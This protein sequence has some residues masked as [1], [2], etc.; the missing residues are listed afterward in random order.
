[1]VVKIGLVAD[2]QGDADALEYACDLLVE[3]GAER[4]FFLGG[5]WSDVDELF[6]RKRALQRGGREYS[7]RD[8]LADVATFVAKASG[9]EKGTAA[10]ATKENPAEQLIARFARVPDKR[11]LQYRDPAVPRVLPEL[12]GDRIVCLVHDKADLSREDIESATLLIHGHGME[13]AAVQ[14]GSR[15]FLTPGALAGAAT[16]ACALLEVARE[17]S[18]FVGLGLDGRE[19]VRVALSLAGKK[20]MTAR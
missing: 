17:G 14:I 5:F 13:P 20:K 6:G 9:S 12:V 7:D 10:R 2:S 4:L 19:L 8:F 3:C 1:L 16:P 15:Y 18:S 11:S